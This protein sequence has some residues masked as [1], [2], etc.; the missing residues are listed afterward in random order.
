MKNN[1]KMCKQ[2]LGANLMVSSGEK[3]TIPARKGKAAQVKKGQ[4]I[5]VINTHG[6]QVVDTWAFNAHDTSEFMSMEHSRA[7]MLKI[8]PAV[9]DSLVTNRRRPILT[10][11]EDTT[12]GVH[13]T[14]LAACDRYRYELLGV[15]GYHDSCTD[16]LAAAM[17]EVEAKLPETPSPL[18]LFMNIPVLDGNRVEFRPPESK[19]NQYIALRAEMD[20]IV[21]FSA[22][23]QDKVP[24]NGLACTPTDAHFTIE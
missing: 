11:T 1:I 24:V 10:V 9:G 17:K 23:P 15:V 20:L 18:N 19:P 21:A 7:M 5:K 22:C 4:I 2:H 14:L 16:N 12:P 3:I 6:Q 13:D 8:V